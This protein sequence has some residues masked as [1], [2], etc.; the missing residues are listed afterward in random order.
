M[1]LGRPAGFF[2]APAFAAI[3]LARAEGFFNGGLAFCNQCKRVCDIQWVAHLFSGVRRRGGL[4]CGCALGRE[5][6]LA[7]RPCGK[8]SQWNRDQQAADG[9]L[10]RTKIPFS[11]PCVIARFSW[12]AEVAV[13]SMWYLLSTN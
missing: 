1:V 7:R 4:V 2:P 13:R 8:V 3:A 12:L 6:D 9:P 5:L 10:G 11:D